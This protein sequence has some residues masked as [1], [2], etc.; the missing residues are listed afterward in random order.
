ML[1]GMPNLA[2][3][4]YKQDDYYY[5][6]AGGAS[7]IIRVLVRCSKHSLETLDI[8]GEF[9]RGYPIF[10]ENDEDC[11]RGFKALKEGEACPTAQGLPKSE[12][13]DINR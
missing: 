5:T 3:F 6:Q 7:D 11:F 10:K 1:I 12:K 13:A 8:S 2:H 4:V 9:G